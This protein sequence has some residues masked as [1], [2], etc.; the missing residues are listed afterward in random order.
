LGIAAYWSRLITR[1]RPAADAR[2]GMADRDSHVFGA[3][4]FAASI[5]VILLCYRLVP[6]RGTGGGS[7]A[8]ANGG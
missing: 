4:V 3:L 5:L 1:M 2:D 6:R 8:A 7:F